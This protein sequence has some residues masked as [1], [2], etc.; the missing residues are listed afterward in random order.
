MLTYVY[1][2]ILLLLYQ[3]RFPIHLPYCIQGWPWDN[4]RK[5]WARATPHPGQ[6]KGKK[7]FIHIHKKKKNYIYKIKFLLEGKIKNNHNPR[8]K[9]IFKRQKNI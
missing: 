4:P 3:S 1:L 6:P 7:K 9:K 2:Y 8:G 5:P